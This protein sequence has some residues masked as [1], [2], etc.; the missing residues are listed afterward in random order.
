MMFGAK[1]GKLKDGTLVTLRPMM[2]SDEEALYRFFQVLPD[3]LLIFIRHNVKE[4]K[5]IQEWVKRLN[6]SRVLPLLALVG[7]EIVA[8]VTLH[9]VPHG[10]KRH[11]GR[12]RIVVAP[13]YQKL[14]LATLMLNEMVEL[15]AELG[16]EKLW[17]EVPLD[18][19]GA[20]GAFRNAGYVCKAVIEGL[21]KDTTNQNRDILIMICDIA[22]YFDQ[23]WARQKRG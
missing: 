4:R 18:S 19:R 13:A 14:G 22:S 1:T 7:D 3:D 9:R 15:A 20:I 16:L 2:E 5:V 8:D 21:V 10:W 23:R 12:I 11:I 17:A 6:Y